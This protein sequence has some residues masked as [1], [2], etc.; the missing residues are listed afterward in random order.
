MRHG[1][2]WHDGHRAGIVRP[3]AG[4]Y[5][6]FASVVEA[7]GPADAVEFRRRALAE[8]TRM[9]APGGIMLDRGAVACLATA[10]AGPR[11]TGE[12]AHGRQPGQGPAA[13]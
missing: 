6:G 4:R 10:P 5:D 1:P 2:S 8:L 7:L 13:T 3:L 12:S 11:L 9:H